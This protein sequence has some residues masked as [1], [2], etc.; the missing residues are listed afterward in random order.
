M[1][2]EVEVTLPGGQKIKIVSL[3]G[4]PDDSIILVSPPNYRP[5]RESFERQIEEMIRDRRAVATINI[6]LPYLRGK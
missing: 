5:F 2:D 4:I 1:R 6:G 3:E